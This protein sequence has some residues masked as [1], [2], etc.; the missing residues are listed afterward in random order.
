[1]T[2]FVK[3]EVLVAERYIEVIRNKLNDLGV[4]TVGNYDHVI[5]YSHVRGFW[6]PLDKAEP[7]EGRKGE[8]SHGSE[9]KMEFRCPYE[10]IEDVK[11]VIVS[12]HPYEEPVMYIIPLL[13]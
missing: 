13:T 2:E 5:S 3:F 6:R 11:E 9:C 12:I 10:K 8:I 1:M 4:L 7:V